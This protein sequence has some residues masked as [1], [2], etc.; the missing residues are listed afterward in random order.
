MQTKGQKIAKIGI[1][2]HFFSEKMHKNVY[3]LSKN[4]KTMLDKSGYI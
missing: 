2:H 3:N 4:P 1:E